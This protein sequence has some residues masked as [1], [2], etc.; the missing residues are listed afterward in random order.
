MKTEKKE[1]NE[2]ISFL[3]QELKKEKWEVDERVEKENQEKKRERKETL[4]ELKMAFCFYIW[5]REVKSDTKQ[6]MTTAG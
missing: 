5:D 1:K 2:R 6:R 3:T 4:N